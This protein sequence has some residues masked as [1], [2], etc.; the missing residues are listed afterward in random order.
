L[1]KVYQMKLKMLAVALVA[2]SACT[3]PPTLDDYRPVVDPAK[4]N[5]K[6]FEADL[7]ACRGIAKSAEADYTQRAQQEA[8]NQMVAGLLIG[9]IAGAAVGGNGQSTA[10]GAA[11]GGAVG[12]AAEGDYTHDLVTYGPRRIVDRCMTERG[13]VILSDIG[14]G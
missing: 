7:T 13:H 1:K 10:A 14:R 12:A 5:S 11:Y 4:T 9:A 8:Q 3:P 6:K 2:L